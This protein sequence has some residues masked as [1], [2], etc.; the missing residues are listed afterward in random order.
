V[1]NALT[2]LRERRLVDV[3]SVGELEGHNT[4][5]AAYWRLTDEGRAELARRRS[6]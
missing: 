4:R 3:L 2:D 6:A 5:A 1:R